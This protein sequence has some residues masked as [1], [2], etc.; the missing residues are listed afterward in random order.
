MGWRLLRQRLPQI[1]QGEKPKADS[2]NT[3]ALVL[4]LMLRLAREKQWKGTVMDIQVWLTC[5]GAFVVLFLVAM[6]AVSA[7]LHKAA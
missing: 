7:M 3:A 4:C 2:V 5:V 6:T 1:K